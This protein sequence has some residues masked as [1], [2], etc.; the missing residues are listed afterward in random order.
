[1]INQGYF[2]LSME[3]AGMENLEPQGLRSRSEMERE[4]RGR[5]GLPGCHRVA[6]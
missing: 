1:M 6:R 4:E 5:I 3:V 2:Y